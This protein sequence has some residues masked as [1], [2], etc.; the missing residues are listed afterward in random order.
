MKKIIATALLLPLLT[1]ALPGF[2]QVTIDFQSQPTRK[3]L[4]QVVESATRDK[5]YSTALRVAN[6]AIK[7]F[8]NYATAYFYRAIAEYN[9]GNPKDARLDFEQAKK[10]Y[11][12]QLKSA[13]ISAQEKSEAQVKLETVEQNLLLLQF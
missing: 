5:N 13:K 2:T 7:L 6:N 4:I 3:Q 9:I 1:F 10:L 11:L 8:P 12:S